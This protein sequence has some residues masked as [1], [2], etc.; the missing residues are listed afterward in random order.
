MLLKDI[1][2]PEVICC[3][4]NADAFAAAVLMRQ[5]HVGALVVVN[6]VDGERAPVGLVTDRDLVVEVLAAGRDARATPVGSLM[7][8]P[9]VIAH[10]TE[11]VGAVIERMRTHGVRRIPVVDHKGSVAGIVTLDD[12]LGQV[13]EEA[14]A[15]V[16]TSR[17][18]QKDER[19][20][21]R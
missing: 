16:Q 11:E 15:L 5:H 8:Q 20:L 3:A 1:Y 21:R 12:L 9:V 19:K 10:E 7:R 13:V 2:T 6:D 4:I 14:N 17:R 18:E